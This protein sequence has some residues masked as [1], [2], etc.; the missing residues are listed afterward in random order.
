MGIHRKGRHQQG[1]DG[2]AWFRSPPGAWC[3]SP[4]QPHTHILM[5][6]HPPS[7]FPSTHLRHLSSANN[8]PLPR[9]GIR[10]KSLCSCLCIP[11]G[12]DVVPGP[13]AAVLL[14]TPEPVCPHPLPA[15]ELLTPGR[16]SVALV[17]PSVHIQ[18]LL[19]SL[20]F[21]LGR[22]PRSAGPAL[23]QYTH[24]YAQR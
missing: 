14:S 16:G 3:Y 4:R 11:W 2:M 19:T 22:K 1:R 12:R 24:S 20:G 18:F 6:E 5:S 17:G 8:P 15:S 7:H 23:T 21:Y 13:L 9:G 10:P